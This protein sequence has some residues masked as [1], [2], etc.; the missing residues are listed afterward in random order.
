MIVD[1]QYL[2]WLVIH[3]YGCLD[4]GDGSTPVRVSR[5]IM[6]TAMKLEAA[7]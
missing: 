6:R 4:S 7:G 3:R 5:R 2:D 1:D